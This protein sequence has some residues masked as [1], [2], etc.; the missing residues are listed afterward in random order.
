[1][2]RRNLSVG[3][4]FILF[5]FLF[6][7][8]GIGVTP[9]T[10]NP[11][12]LLE[13]FQKEFEPTK[14]LIPPGIIFKTG[15]VEGAGPIIGLVQMEQGQV[16]VVHQ[17]QTAAYQLKKDFPLFMGDWVVTGEKSRINIGLQDQSVFSL[18]P[19][20]KLTID[21][22]V[23]DRQTGARSSRLSL[24]FGRARFVVTPG[25]SKESNY[26]V[27]T[28]TAVCGVRGSDFALAVT[29]NA[30]AMTSF[31]PFSLGQI[32]SFSTAYAA[33]PEYLLTTLVTGPNTVVIFSGT[34]GPAQTVG[35]FSTSAAA[36]SG[37]ALMPA[38]VG[39]AAG[40]ALNTVGPGLASSS[41]PPQ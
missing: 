29:P 27:K 4:L 18:A 33:V 21:K 30:D 14:P 37:A 5:L 8:N 26:E 36:G 12:R 20:T 3:L 28:P 32:F 24:F 7:R 31:R 39:T 19:F 22:S 6:L 10:A 11:E 16:Y 38:S 2:K 34:V 41:M 1:M 25:L 35:P 17:G 40:E 23:Y 9:L 15:F 13:N